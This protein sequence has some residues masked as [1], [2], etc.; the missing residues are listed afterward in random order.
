MLQ[1]LLKHKT[2]PYG[3]QVAGVAACIYA[4]TYAHYG[5]VGPCTNLNK[6][7]ADSIEV[8]AE[9]PSISCS[10]DGLPTSQKKFGNIPRLDRC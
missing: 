10:A 5:F 8:Q 4:D 7:I 9:S 1:Y 6:V 2:Q 3:S